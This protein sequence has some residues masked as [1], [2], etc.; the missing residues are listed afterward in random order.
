FKDVRQRIEQLDVAERRFDL[1]VVT[2][3][4]LDHIGGA[5]E[6][7]QD[8]ALGVRYNDVWFND[9]HHLSDE[10]ATRGALQ[11][12]FLANVL[13]D[14]KLPWN[15]AFG[16]GPVRVEPNRPLPRVRLEGD[17]TLEGMSEVT[18]HGKMEILGQSHEISIPLRIQ[19]NGGRFTAGA[20]FE[21]PYVEWGLDD[22]STFVLRVAKEVQVMIEAAGTIV[23]TDETSR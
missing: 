12:E 3:I 4:D 9:Y 21:I 11:G 22:P 19:I 6:L 5:I 8:E 10:P 20:E 2:H 17:L 18:L 23:V 13:T 7:L 15:Q 14:A 16:G 1:M